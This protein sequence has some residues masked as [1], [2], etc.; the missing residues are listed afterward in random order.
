M[1]ILRTVGLPLQPKSLTSPSSPATTSSSQLPKS[2][3]FQIVNLGP[4]NDDRLHHRILQRFVL[5]IPRSIDDLLG[6]VITFDYFAENRVIARQP[7]RRRYRDE[8]LR[9]IGIRA[10]IGHG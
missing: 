5:L 9:A 3:F 10:R 8:E 7:R 4:L 2:R 6:H 1:P